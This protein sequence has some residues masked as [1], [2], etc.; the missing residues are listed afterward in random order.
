V[1]GHDAHD[2]GSAQAPVPTTGLLA[3]LDQ[4][5]EAVALI[6]FVAM[7]GAVLLQVAARFTA[8]A[9]IWTEELARLL[10]VV[11]ALLG[12]AVAVRRR[13]HIVVD[14]FVARLAPRTRA[15]LAITLDLAVIG[16]LLIWLR[17]AVRLA[18]L[19]AG[20]AYV[21]LPGVSVAWLYWAEVVA[22]CLSLLFLVGDLV[23]RVRAL[24]W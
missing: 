21:T 2:A 6:L 17:G 24:R 8:V 20:T 1:S 10:L 16:F 7:I 23:A 11:S 18:E 14:Y 3:R 4:V 12:I 13:E 15:G 19:N 22:I 9:V 5:V